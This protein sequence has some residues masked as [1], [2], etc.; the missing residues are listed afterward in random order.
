MGQNNDP[1]EHG[2]LQGQQG[3]NLSKD[4]LVHEAER[5]DEEGYGAARKPTRL[6]A[7]H[8]DARRG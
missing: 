8:G 1:A 2:D 4:P 7:E 6:P 5:E 3:G